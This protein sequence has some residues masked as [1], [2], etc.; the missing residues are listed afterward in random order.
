MALYGHCVGCS[1]TAWLNEDG[2]CSAGHPREQ[3]SGIVDQEEGAAAPQGKGVKRFLTDLKKPK[4]PEEMESREARDEHERRVESARASLAEAA[5]PYD[6][7]IDGARASLAA[8]QAIGSVN[9]SAFSGMRLTERALMT[10]SGVIDLESQEVRVSVETAGSLSHTQRST[11][12][13]IGLGTLIAPGVG[14]VV[15]A[16][17]KKNKKHDDRELYVVV[18]S[19]TVSAVVSCDPDKGAQAR[20]FAASVQTTAAGAPERAMRRAELVPQWVRHTD[21][22]II[23]RASALRPLREALQA[24]RAD[25]ARLDT[26]QATLSEQ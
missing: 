11:L 7:E 2:S 3:V 9:V 14:T 12:T 8:A 19:S 13:R 21:D 4:T 23:R 25:T 20:Q 22:L 10:P 6:H 18:E 1:G 24:A 26:A 16:V 5:A 17:A 15:G